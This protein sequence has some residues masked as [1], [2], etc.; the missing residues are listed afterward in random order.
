MT[1]ADMPA[2]RTLLAPLDEPA[3]VRLP[4]PLLLFLV[5]LN[6]PLPPLMKWAAPM[7]PDDLW[8]IGARSALGTL[9]TLACLERCC[10]FRLYRLATYTMAAA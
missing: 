10:F 7:P 6:G 2:S 3:L 5:A 4:L 8:L 1:G 9:L